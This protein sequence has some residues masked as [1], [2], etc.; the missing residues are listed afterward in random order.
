[1]SRFNPVPSGSGGAQSRA[2]SNLQSALELGNRLVTN[3]L[4]LGLALVNPATFPSAAT[5]LT[6]AVCQRLS[7]GF[8]TVSG[9]NGGVALRELANKAEV[10]VLVLTVGRKIG[11][12]SSPPFPL[13]ELVHRAYQ[14]LS[15]YQALW[16]VEGLGHDYA[17]SFFKQGIE[18]VGILTEEQQPDL[19]HKSLLILH[20]GIGLA[21]AQQGLS[22]ITPE[23]PIAEIR[24]AVAR[25]IRLSRVNSRPGYAGVAFE[26]LGLQTYDFH[27]TSLTPIIDRVL[28]EIDSEVVPYFWHGV[29]RAIYF[30]APL[31]FLP[32][33]GWQTF[34][35]ARNL[36]PDEFALLNAWTGL[37]W[38][39]TLV[40]LAQPEIL[41]E[42]LIRF[43][44]HELLENDGFA[45][46]VASSTN[47]RFDTT[48][49][50][51]AI[52]SFCEYRSSDPAVDRQ[53]DELVRAPCRRALG[54]YFPVLRESETEHWKD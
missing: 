46:G 37:A 10:F 27:P 53:W 50:A 51:P 9:G 5:G 23:T 47:M 17:Y 6:N 1:M 4:D 34:Q 16:G 41:A 44:G 40:N 30:D 49:G 54:D 45:N 38:A 42:L 15:A 25:I 24:R 21:F 32:C 36:A 29:G 39:W 14:K 7:E 20:A 31:N 35:M 43:H 19:P 3:T 28:R 13:L 11:V 18:P 8:R 12:P 22:N 2:G 33:S 26:S 52:K 48:P